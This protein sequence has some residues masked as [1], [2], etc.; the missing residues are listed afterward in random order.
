MS[1]DMV[2]KGSHEGCFTLGAVLFVIAMIVL[3]FY[4]AA[5]R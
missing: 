1:G 2:D 3:Y 4:G 5:H